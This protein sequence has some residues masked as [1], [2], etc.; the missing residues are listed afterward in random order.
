MKNLI[1]IL[2]LA[3]VVVMQMP[4]LAGSC[5]HGLRNETCPF[6]TR[7]EPECLLYN[8][9]RI[10]ELRTSHLTDFGN[11]RYVIQF[12]AEYAN[13]EIE[14]LLTFLEER[15]LVTP[16]TIVD[17]GETTRIGNLV[18]SGYSRVQIGQRFPFLFQGQMNCCDLGA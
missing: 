1:P 15:D 2:A 6:E 11:S 4:L 12:V 5:P 14:V 9:R 10:V 8:G 16:V 18:F 17:Q 3:L 13:G 7:W